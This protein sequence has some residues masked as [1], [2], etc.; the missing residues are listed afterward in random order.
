MTYKM[1]ANDHWGSRNRTGR[2]LRSNNFTRS[3][4]GRR[5]RLFYN[6]PH[7]HLVVPTAKG[8]V[9][10]RQHCSTGSNETCSRLKGLKPINKVPAR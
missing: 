4:G 2:V 7:L 6:G 8:D 5:Y 1:G 10:G 9:L 3:I